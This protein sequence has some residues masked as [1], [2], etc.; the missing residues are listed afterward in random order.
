MCVLELHKNH[1]SYAICIL[2]IKFYLQMETTVRNSDSDDNMY[3]YHQ[4]CEWKWR[5]LSMIFW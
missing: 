4:S 2:K 1:V 3:L 5:C